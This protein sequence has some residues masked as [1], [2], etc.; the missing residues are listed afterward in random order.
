MMIRY[1]SQ[2]N[3]ERLQFILSIAF[4]LPAF[5]ASTASSMEEPWSV[6]AAS[7]AFDAPA[8]AR[9]LES[10]AR[11]NPL[12]WAVNGFQTFIS[13]VDGDRCTLYPTC[14]AYSK[15][16][17]EKYGA[18]RGFIMTA[19]RL[20]HEADEPSYA[21]LIRKHG[22]LRYYDPVENNDFW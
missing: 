13:P 21:P 6:S 17:I 11:F 12:V 18:L 7:P 22:T 9:E 16:A 1:I 8:Y 2:I 4:F 15:E 20:L 14:S 5:F 19:D 10:S 3:F